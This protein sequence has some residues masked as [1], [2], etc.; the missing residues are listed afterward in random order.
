[1]TQSIKKFLINFL[2]SQLIVT[3]VALPILVA[4]GLP[5]SVMTFI[6]NLVFAPVLTIIIILASLL[7][8]T[9]LVGISNAW[10]AQ[11]FNV[12]VETWDM[13]LKQGKKEWLFAFA[14]P[15]MIALVSIPLIVY[16]FLIYKKITSIGKRIGFMSILL[17]ACYLGLWGHQYFHARHQKFTSP[18]NS[19]FT[20]AHAQGGIIFIDDGFFNSKMSV[21]KAVE[22]ELKSTLI[23]K[24]GTVR[25]QE[26]VLRRPGLRSFAG[27]LEMCKHFS[28]KRVTVPFFKQKLSKK[29]W[30]YFFTLKRVLKN[31]GAILHRC[32]SQVHGRL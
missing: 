6:G 24:Y 19:F 28:V 15:G 8:F 21:D 2:H 32:D 31:N 27:A 4:W 22:F 14:H 16:F 17:A 26:L 30:F 10:L 23:K 9:Q 3:L 7:F 13:L 12:V 18:D 25:I 5:S 20:K 11:A 1:M 29:G